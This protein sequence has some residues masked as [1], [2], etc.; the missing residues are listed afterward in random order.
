MINLSSSGP[1]FA[2]TTP[3]SLNAGPDRSCV[4]CSGS[5]GAASVSSTPTRRGNALGGR[6]GEVQPRQSLPAAGSRS[7]Q[8]GGREAA[9]AGRSSLPVANWG[10]VTPSPS[11]SSL[12][13]SLTDTPSVPVRKVN[14]LAW[15]ISP[16]RRQPQQPQHHKRGTEEP[17]PTILVL[18]RRER[19]YTAMQ[20]IG[21][22]TCLGSFLQSRRTGVCS[23]SRSVIHFSAYD[24]SGAYSRRLSFGILARAKLMARLDIPTCSALLTLGSKMG[25]V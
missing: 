22:G 2:N 12:A 8:L 17:E 15:P 19:E 25:G 23:R 14:H 4:A 7:V 9:A 16:K 18:G 24:I 6:R 11:I 10:L 21:K 3:S 5:D 1:L 20:Q 13:S